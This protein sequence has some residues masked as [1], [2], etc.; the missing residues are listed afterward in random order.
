VNR[1]TYIDTTLRDL[2]TYPW[3]SSIDANDLAV[4]AGAL[5]QVGAQAI[6]VMDPRCARAALELR[7]ESPWDR[8]RAVVRH[9]S[10]TPVGIVV[11]GTMLWHDRP[12]GADVVRQFVL[13][14]A[15]AGVGR[16]R[17]L[18]PL[19]DA[20]AFEAIAAAS[21]E[22]RI[23]FVPTLVA[24]PAPDISDARWER[25]ARALAGLAGAAALCVS[26]GGGHLSPG[27]LARLVEVAAGVT[28]I[29][30][31]VIVQAP[32]GLAPILAQS[33]IESGAR[34]VY[35]AAGALAMTA[36]R[37]SAETLRVALSGTSNAL[38][39]DRD[40]LHAAARIIGP[41]LTPDRLTLAAADLFGPAVALPP[42]LEAALVSRLGR[43][44]MSRSLLDV[45][46]EVR[47]VA[48]E[49]GAATLAYPLGDAIVTQAAD[50]V[51]DGE[52]WTDIEPI[53]AAT[54]LGQLGPVRGPVS[55]E[56][57]AVAQAA[58]PVDT[59]AVHLAAIVHDA[60]RGVSEEDLVLWAQFPEAVQRLIGRR[61]SLRT[62]VA[63]E[64]GAAIDRALLETLIQAVEGSAEAEISVELGGAR[65]TVRRAVAAPLAG[66]TTPGRAGE[67]AVD[68][69]LHHVTSPMVGTF[70][71]A[72]SPDADPFVSE[73]QRVEVGQ[74]L[75]LIEAMKLFNEITADVAGVVRKL[76]VENAQGVEFGDL[77]VLID[78]A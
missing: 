59:D 3:G 68:D 62:E 64:E 73:G 18:D 48:T 40:A 70:Y 30:I 5:A 49:I 29:P 36:A 10:R 39:V 6:E 65:V 51:I 41:M 22:A 7:T 13:S 77:L 1:V 32:G 72:P 75:C 11:H 66:G 28:D 42:D 24:G 63:D 31:E 50:H 21:R 4:A 12:V 61:Q 34:A 19:N 52:R 17:A 20:A 9:A 45:A 2:A 33:A 16:L 35:C 74:T 53:L 71:R 38:S 55:D 8:I 56:V 76:C 54:A 58:S 25:E 60:P 23:G 37:P 67:A 14:A 43:L 78:P 15:E 47:L 57:L 69:G 46:E 44:G 27:Q 26:D